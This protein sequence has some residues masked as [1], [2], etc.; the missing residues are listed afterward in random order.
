MP[1]IYSVFIINKS[2]GLIFNKVCAWQHCN[3][4]MLQLHAALLLRMGQAADLSCQLQEFLSTN[5]LS[6][7]DTLRLASI[8]CAQRASSTSC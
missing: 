4:L 3:A 5:G 8:W 1:G 6:L 2:G 7:N